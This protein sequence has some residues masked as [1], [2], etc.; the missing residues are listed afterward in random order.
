MRNGIAIYNGIGLYMDNTV[1]GAT[2]PFI[3]G[4]PA[5]ATNF[6]F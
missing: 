6:S 5:G 2:T 1:A 4:T 3:G